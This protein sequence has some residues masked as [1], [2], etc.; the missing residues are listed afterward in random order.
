MILDWADAN[1]MPIHILLTK[2]DKLSKSRAKSAFHQVQQALTDWKDLVSIQL[3]S[4]LKK[5]GLEEVE[6]KIEEWFNPDNKDT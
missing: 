1:N 5:T 2:A 6:S 3:F 4:S